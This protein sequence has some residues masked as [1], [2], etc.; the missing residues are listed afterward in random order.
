MK[1]QS[2]MIQNTI[3]ASIASLL[4]AGIAASAGSALA[5]DPAKEK[6]FG[7]SA[8]GKNDCGGAGAKHACAGQSKSDKDPTDW[9]YV[10]KGSCEKMGG[11]LM[12]LADTDKAMPMKK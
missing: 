4:A 1:E 11:K 7:I 5:A 6:C 8:A 2:T 3:K 9:K 12:A 10:D